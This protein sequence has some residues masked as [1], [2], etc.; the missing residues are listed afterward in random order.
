MT[1]EIKKSLE[2]FLF[3]FKIDT[4]A[5]RCCCGCSLKTGVAIIAVLSLLDS[6]IMV[7]HPYQHN[8]LFTLLR[9]ISL[10]LVSTGS[11]FLLLSASNSNLSMAFKGYWLYALQFYI[12]AFYMI[13]Y[14]FFYFHVHYFILTEALIYLTGYIIVILLGLAL[15]LYLVWIIYSYVTY[16]AKGDFN[17]IE[18]NPEGYVRIDQQTATL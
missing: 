1:E 12:D 15:K 6:L 17:T 9:L 10:G 14:I 4:L 11:V 13:I 7:M 2:N 16:F 8:F 5:N 18:N 3:F